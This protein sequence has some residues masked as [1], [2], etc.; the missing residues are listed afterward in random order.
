MEFIAAKD[1]PVTEAEEVDVL[2]VENGEMK[3]KPAK[4]LGGNSYDL[5][6][7][8]W[9]ELDENEKVIRKGEVLEGSFETVKQK[10]DS[11]L[12]AL[13]LV[14]EDCS[15]AG[16]WDGDVYKYIGETNMSASYNPDNL[17]DIIFTAWGWDLNFAILPD[18]TIAFNW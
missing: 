18:N 7:R 2:C 12:P 10:F 17:D 8:L 1:L 5:K 14:I 16:E 3:R 9:L 11:E 6:V 15:N 4:G 13:A